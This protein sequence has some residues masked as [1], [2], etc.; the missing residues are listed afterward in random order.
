MKIVDLS[1]DLNKEIND[2][3]VGP[4]WRKF[5]SRIASFKLKD[6]FG[7]FIHNTLSEISVIIPTKT[8]HALSLCELVVILSDSLQ[9]EKLVCMFDYCD[10]LGLPVSTL[11]RLLEMQ[12]H[13]AHPE[14]ILD[15]L[16]MTDKEAE[17]SVK[18]RVPVATHL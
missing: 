10:K 12:V 18:G 7:H 8:K 15:P 17:K 13:I 6:F 16:G 3:V 5:S 1:E 14:T 2:S 9:M 11:I 4:Q